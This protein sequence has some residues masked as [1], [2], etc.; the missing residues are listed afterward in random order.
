MGIKP[1][2]SYY[3][4]LMK[5]NN[6]YPSLSEMHGAMATVPGNYEDEPG[7]STGLVVMS[8]VMIEAFHH[9]EITDGPTADYFHIIVGWEFF[10]K[11]FGEAF[12]VT[13]SIIPNLFKAMRLAFSKML[14]RYDRQHRVRD[15][16]PP[17]S[18]YLWVMT[19]EYDKYFKP[20]FH[21]A[22][23]SPRVR[24]LELTFFARARN[25]FASP[26]SDPKHAWSVFQD[27]L[28]L[29][30]RGMGMWGFAHKP[31]VGI[32]FRVFRYRKWSLVEYVC[33]VFLQSGTDNIL[34]M[35]RLDGTAQL[36]TLLEYAP[37]PLTDIQRDLI[38]SNFYE[39]CHTFLYDWK[40][41]EKY[42]KDYVR[43]DLQGSNEFRR[44][45]FR[46]AIDYVIGIKN[47]VNAN[48]EML[49]IGEAPI[50]DPMLEHLA[51][52]RE[53]LAFTTMVE[54][55]DDFNPD[56]LER[57]LLGL[58]EPVTGHPLLHYTD[59]A[60]LTEEEK[61]AIEEGTVQTVLDERPP[62][63]NDDDF[64]EVFQRNIELPELLT[65][66]TT[67][68][69][70]VRPTPPDAAENDPHPPSLYDPF[71]ES[72][73][74]PDKW[75]GA[76][77]PRDAIEAQYM[78]DAI[79][80]GSLYADL[81]YET[82]RRYAELSNQRQ[83]VD[84]MKRQIYE[85]LGE[86]YTTISEKRAIFAQLLAADPGER[87]YNVQEI[88]HLLR[89]WM[90]EVASF[91]LTDFNVAMSLFIAEH[92]WIPDEKTFKQMKEWMERSRRVMPAMENVDA[93]TRFIR[94][95]EELRYAE[96]WNIIAEDDPLLTNL[97]EK[98][99][100]RFKQSALASGLIEWIE[101]IFLVEFDKLVR[102][103]PTP[104][105]LTLIGPSNSGKSLLL[106]TLFTIEVPKR[107]GNAVRHA[108][109][110]KSVEFNMS[111]FQAKDINDPNTAYWSLGDYNTFDDVKQ[112]KTLQNIIDCTANT[113][114]KYESLSS[115]DIKRRP[116][117]MCIGIETVEMFKE[118][119]RNAYRREAPGLVE[120]LFKRLQFLQ[121]PA[122]VRAEIP[123]EGRFTTVY[124]NE[125][126]NFAEV[127]DSDFEVY[128]QNNNGQMTEP[129]RFAVYRA[130]R[131]WKWIS[132][133][134]SK[135]MLNRAEALARNRLARM[136]L[137]DLASMDAETRHI[138]L[139]KRAK[140]VVML[141]L[142]DDEAFAQF[143][144]RGGLTE[145]EQRRVDEDIKEMERTKKEL[146]RQKQQQLDI[147]QLE[148]DLMEQQVRQ[149]EDPFEDDIF[150]LREE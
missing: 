93:M 60:L 58:P 23:H 31:L 112:L 101:K 100:T 46:D 136:G 132:E 49:A 98:S 44:P 24:D 26:S 40:P 110:F 94:D 47:F 118:R 48:P 126:L 91:G 77:M 144:A 30:M 1:P 10:E 88:K 90:Y 82:R 37:M 57:Q 13:E 34:Y 143:L 124:I 59:K 92:K 141:R 41:F 85:Q 72:R 150:L 128:E 121:M 55:L 106:K 129:F 123:V 68:P 5:I 64:G 102:V 81:L 104:K 43:A 36:Q 15:T 7:Y 42:F 138:A 74:W 145:E 63:T 103:K 66:H 107:F 131:F 99:F 76:P 96:M 22:I 11:H 17:G 51:P 53:R 25:E 84:A 116:I 108:P 114:I 117:I 134:I 140:E 133:L 65:I 73:D 14:R 139:A 83:A 109:L 16:Q 78:H 2:G 125:W 142:Q 28:I 86:Q 97:W 80:Y 62:L 38:A 127:Y 18:E 120:Q 4:T 130:Y 27:E 89:E 71:T 149:Q 148:Y 50:D 9:R 12:D 21:F 119:L 95:C 35:S 75:T 69:Q 146:K 39:Y 79:E 137:L 67:L 45:G 32:S 52:A 105:A 3:L 147:D 19:V 70:I 54:I 113:D 87:N 56:E 20:H 8:H 29:S 33:K 6:T 111:A 61:R 135:Q 115:A 122:P